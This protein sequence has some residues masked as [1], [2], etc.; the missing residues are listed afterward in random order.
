VR[1][2]K[3]NDAILSSKKTYPKLFENRFHAQLQVIGKE[4]HIANTVR[5]TLSV[6]DIYLVALYAYLPQLLG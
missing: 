1:E 6:I 4:N 5:G 3:Y 2:K